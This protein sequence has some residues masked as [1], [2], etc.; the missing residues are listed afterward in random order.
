M[1]SPRYRFGLVV[2]AASVLLAYK[3]LTIATLGLWPI[4]IG[5][6]LESAVLVSWWALFELGRPQANKYLRRTLSTLFYVGFYVLVVVSIA[7]TFFFESAAERRISLL[8]VDLRTLGYFFSR[9]LPLRGLLLMLGLLVA[10]HALAY[11]IARISKPATWKLRALGIAAMWVVVL[12]VLA[13]NPRPPSPLADMGIDLWEQLSM[14]EVVVDRRQKAPYAPSQLDKSAWPSEALSPRFDKVLVFVMETMT[15]AVMSEQ[16]KLLGERT[17]VHAA[18]P[19]AHVFERYFATNQDSRTGMLSMLGSRFIPYEAYSEDGRDHYMKLG[20]KSSLVEHFNALGYRTAFAVSQQEIELVVGDL[21]WNDKLHLEEGDA[22]RLE[23]QKFLCFVPYEF[24]HSC[25]DRALLPRV[26]DYIDKHERVFLYQEFIWGHA[27]EYNKASGRTNTEYYSAYLDAVIQHLEQTSALDRTLIVLTSDHGFRDKSLQSQRD[28]YQIPLLFYATSFTGSTDTRLL[29]HLD[30]KDLLLRELSPGL[31][32]REDNPY[33]MI[34][35]PTGTS[36]LTVLTQSG[37]MLLMKA[38]EGERYL[39]H[40]DGF[41]SAQA[42]QRAA[43]DFLRLFED[44]L[45]YFGA[46]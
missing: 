1:L 34:I 44:Y 29:S 10:I 28:V 14:P 31:P 42:G 33:L 27:S 9:V 37:Q 3:L 8:E 38:R 30:F 39:V 45:T 36:F 18:R 7:H 32:P 46:L 16:K 19:H 26:L 22:K 25:E 24:E 21:P 6:Q 41:A 20:D 4:A 5:W 43:G 15:S 23:A 12:A 2:G 11:P 17:F 35:G 13:S 40:Q